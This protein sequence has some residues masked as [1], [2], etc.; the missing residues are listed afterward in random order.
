[1]DKGNLKKIA[2]DAKSVSKSEVKQIVKSLLKE[3]QELKLFIVQGTS[4]STDY[5]GACT[6]LSAIPQG[7][8]DI[9]R[10][11][12]RVQLM[13]WSFRWAAV[14]GDAYNLVRVVLFQW[15]PDTASVT[16]S[17]SN[18]IQTTGTINAPLS[19]KSI[20]FVK[21]VHVLYDKTVFVDTYHPV[22]VNQVL[23]RRFHDKQMQFTGATSRTNGLFILYISDSAAVTHPAINYYSTIRYT[24]S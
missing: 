3:V 9:T 7:D 11:G 22:M 21:N 8:T 19:Y 17:P 15:T 12:D 14:V 20:D 2:K 24:D 5:N 10:D 4:T 13:E 6:D 18:V 23:I 16:P 1:M